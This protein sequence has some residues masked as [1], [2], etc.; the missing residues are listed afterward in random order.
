MTD[1]KEFTGDK[2]ENTA[3]LQAKYSLMLNKLNQVI[4]S[5]FGI[6]NLYGS[7]FSFS[8]NK[9]FSAKL[10]LDNNIY[11]LKEICQDIDNFQDPS[12]SLPIEPNI[13]PIIRQ[14]NI[15]SF[16]IFSSQPEES[17]PEWY[18]EFNE[19]ESL[20][21]FASVWH[22]DSFQQKDL[23]ISYAKWQCFSPIADY[24]S[25]V[26]THLVVAFQSGERGLNIKEDLLAYNAIDN[27]TYNC[28]DIFPVV[29]SIDG[30]IAQV[31]LDSTE[32]SIP[33]D[34]KVDTIDH[35]FASPNYTTIIDMISRDCNLTLNNKEYKI[36]S[37]TD[38][39]CILNW[40]IY[41]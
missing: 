4:N 27:A 25:Q 41:W 13:L 18:V 17:I 22:K 19:T 12:G 39:D 14:A 21:N 29:S 7:S 15:G 36:P 9:N 3:E 8:E 31:M 35:S 38:I 5:I 33:L 23:L 32:H 24:L 34:Y 26:I 37:S 1:D 20:L 6:A 10:D 2:V 40:E 16:Q 30:V 11:L 28:I